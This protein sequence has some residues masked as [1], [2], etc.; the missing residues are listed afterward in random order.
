MSAA[1]AHSKPRLVSSAAAADEPQAARATKGWFRRHPILTVILTLVLLA[2]IGSAV[3]SSDNTGSSE[4][5][6]IQAAVN[7]STPSVPPTPGPS[8]MT[9]EQEQAVQ[10]AKSYL[11]LGKGFSRAG[12]IKQLSSSYGEGFP[13]DVAVF[14]VDSLNVDWDAQAV[15]SAK[16]YMSLGTGFS[17]AGLIQQMS[18]SYGEGFTQAQASYAADAVGL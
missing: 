16:S 2:I 6:A 14:A 12:L 8:D 13:R 5:S 10:S 1:A 4:T 11:S 3:S 17:R 18:T 9:T 15:A 7:A